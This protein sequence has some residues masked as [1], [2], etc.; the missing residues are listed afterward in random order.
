MVHGWKE[1]PLLRM[2]LTVYLT[3]PAS[4]SWTTLTDVVI[5]PA[6]LALSRQRLHATKLI[7]SCRPQG[8]GYLKS[9]LT[10]GGFDVQ[11]VIVLPDVKELSREEVT[12]L[13][14]E[15]LGTEFANLAEQL[16]EADVGLPAGHRS[17]RTATGQEGHYP[18]LAGARRGV[19]RYCTFP[20][21]E[22]FLLAKLATVS[23]RLCANLYWT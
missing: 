5:L 18:G 21:F 1:Y 22:I 12:E 19:P 2:E 6:L 17:G 20:G 13:G 4:W 7:L 15:A 23:T 10:Q 11:E 16:A 9:Q 14:R 3:N 8:I